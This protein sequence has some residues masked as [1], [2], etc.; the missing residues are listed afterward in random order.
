NEA[1]LHEIEIAVELER[2]GVEELRGDSRALEDVAP[3][4]AVIAHVVD[5]KDN[6][7][8]LN[9]RVVSV[10]AAQKNRDE[11]GLPIVAME[12][13]RRPNVLGDFDGGPAEFAVTLRIVAEFALCTAV[14]AVAIEI[15]GIVDEEVADAV[16]G[17]AVSNG[18]KPNT[19]AHRYGE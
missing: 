19:I 2:S 13:I 11:S 17:S 4:L 3:I 12:D 6:R 1:A 18:W 15:S 7:E 8:I 16:D 5:G 9:E 10:G 14:D